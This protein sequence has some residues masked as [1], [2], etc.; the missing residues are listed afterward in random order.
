MKVSGE[1]TATRGWDTYW[2]GTYD[3]DSFSAGGARHPSIA[4]FWS[5]TLQRLLLPATTPYRSLDVAT[6]AGAVVDS[7]LRVAPGASVEVTCVDIS[8]S[9]VKGVSKRF[10]S[11]TGV[12]ADARSIPLGDASFDLVTSQFGI[13]YAG[14]EALDECARLLA[15]EGHL[16]L[17]MHIRPG[18]VFN[19]CRASLEAVRRLTRARLVERASRFFEAGFAAVRGADRNPYE[20]AGRELNPAIR[21]TE[22]IMSEL[23]Q[24]VAGGTV[25]KLYADIERIHTRLQHYE[26][27]EVLDWLTRMGAELD[28]YSQ[29]MA[30]MCDAAIDKKTFRKMRRQLEERGLTLVQAAPL[31]P[32]GSS[33]PVAWTIHATGAAES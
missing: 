27:Q 20:K 22:A 32:P 7:L 19:E 2:K 33:L 24:D 13:E 11:V 21:E 29:R 6:G 9:A 8:E 31:V 17:M 4:E 26:P 1:P 28:A 15:P 30:S 14:T 5:E 16:V 18:I 10:P 3:T 12:V 25:A 23:G